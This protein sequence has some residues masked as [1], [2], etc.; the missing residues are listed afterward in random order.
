MSC[1]TSACNGFVNCQQ[2]L[3]CPAGRCM[4]KYIPP[5]ALPQE[6]ENNGNSASLYSVGPGTAL[7]PMEISITNS[8]THLEER[9]I[10]GGIPW[11]GTGPLSTQMYFMNVRRSDL[12]VIEGEEVLYYGTGERNSI[13]AFYQDPTSSIWYLWSCTFGTFFP[14]TTREFI[15]MVPMIVE[16]GGAWVLNRG[17]DSDFPAVFTADAIPTLVGTH[18]M[19]YAWNGENPNGSDILL[20]GETL[21][22]Q[23]VD[24]V[25]N[26]GCALD[27]YS[28]SSQSW[29]AKGNEQLFDLNLCLDGQ[30]LLLT[31]T[32][33][34]LPV[35]VRVQIGEGTDAAPFCE[36][37]GCGEACSIVYFMVT[38]R[39]GCLPQLIDSGSTENNNTV[40]NMWIVI[41]VLLLVI[42]ILVIIWI[43]IIKKDRK[44]V[45]TEVEEM[46]LD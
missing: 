39:N 6:I 29:L 38:E 30:P 44:V 14:N 15:T 2:E 4:A 7:S 33:Q 23:S 32:R 20:Y 1:I 27:P 36:N 22:F 18:Y 34:E 16:D 37:V 25:D 3:N 19:F 11:E 40:R 10:V 8:I 5:I 12:R 42:A 41:G 31:H 45:V 9:I 43:V 21:A 13:M 35:D 28:C 26:T 17:E 46:R 24:I